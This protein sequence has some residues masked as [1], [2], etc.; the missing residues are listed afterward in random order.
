MGNDILG[1]QYRR[2]LCPLFCACLWFSPLLPVEAAGANQSS[3]HRVREAVKQAVAL[4][5][6]DANVDELSMSDRNDLD[7]ELSQIAEKTARPVS[8]Y[9]FYDDSPSDDGSLWVSFRVIHPWDL[10]SCTALRLQTASSNH[11][12]SSTGC[13]LI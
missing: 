8:F 13:C 9:S 12:K 4:A 5:H 2:W 7:E 3:D 11:R 6:P 1:Q 10:M